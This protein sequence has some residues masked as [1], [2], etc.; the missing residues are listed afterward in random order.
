MRKCSSTYHPK[1]SKYKKVFKGSDETFRA[2]WDAQEWLHEHGFSYGSTDGSPYCPIQKGEYTLPQKL[3]NF[4]A[5][6]KAQLAG[7][8]RSFDYR[9]GDVEIWLYDEFDNRDNNATD[10][11]QRQAN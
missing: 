9:N 4:D 11:I 10:R 5:E 2:S 8:M 7:V 1:A 3:Y 6:D